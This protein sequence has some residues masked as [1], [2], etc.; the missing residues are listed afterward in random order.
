MYV[1]LGDI[2]FRSDK[3]YYE[4][5]YNEFLS[6]YREWELNEPN[7]TLILAGDVVHSAS[8]GGIVVSFLEQFARD[9]KFDEVH[10]VVGNHDKKMIHGKQ[11]LAYDFLSLKENF[12]IHDEFEELPIG[13]SKMWLCPYYLGLDK[14]GK[15]MRE[16]YSE[17]YKLPHD[18]VVGL[19]GHFGDPK[20]SFQGATDCID[21]LDKLV[22]DGVKVC[23]GH[24]HTRVT[25]EINIGSV[26]AQSKVENDDR[27]SAWIYD[28]IKCKW[29]ECPL[30]KFNEFLEVEYPKELPKSDA[31]VPIYTVTNCA[32]EAVARTLYGDVEIR[33]VTASKTDT[34][35][36]SEAMGIDGEGTM[37]LDVAQMFREFRESMSKTYNKETL[38]EVARLLG[39]DA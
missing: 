36:K 4:K 37:D 9:T 18:N 35:S 22:E 32:S 6:W 27:R 30:P 23:L 8:N 1:I 11:Q 12:Y 33:K 25:P 10:I 26:V 29:S 14:E 16:A 38:D 31:L 5:V 28:D 21:N 24:I 13:W 3:T 20:S 2:H 17:L 34:T 15:T 19:V 39:V 7:N